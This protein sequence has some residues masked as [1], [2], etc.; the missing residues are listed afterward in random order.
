M[1]AEPGAFGREVERMT[2]LGRLTPDVWMRAAV[3]APVSAAPLI[4]AAE[5]AVAAL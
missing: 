1:A 5:R 2:T 3:G 4:E